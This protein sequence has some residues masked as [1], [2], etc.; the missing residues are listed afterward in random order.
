MELK[1]GGTYVTFEANCSMLYMLML[2]PV[3]HCKVLQLPTEPKVTATHDR[4]R[5]RN[6]TTQL[7]LL[8]HTTKR[9]QKSLRGIV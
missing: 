1:Y 2:I 8:Q 9:E 6:Q 7:Q 3:T 5:T 4:M